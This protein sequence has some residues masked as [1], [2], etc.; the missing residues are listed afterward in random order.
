MVLSC[1]KKTISLRGVTSKHHG[2]FYCLNYLYSFRTENIL[3]S[4]ERVCKSNDFCGI[5]MLL[6]KDNIL[7]FNHHIKW[8]KCH[9]ST[10]WAFD[11]IETK[12]TLYHG[13]D[14]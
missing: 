5:V 14:V 4:R 6:E 11:P 8:D 9:A 3:K 12:H 1:S 2:D 10:I 13:K 7:E